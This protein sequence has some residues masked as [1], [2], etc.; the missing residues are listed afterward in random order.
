MSS[1]STNR[2]T[3]QFTIFSQTVSRWYR[4][5]YVR[6]IVLTLIFTLILGGVLSQTGWFASTQVKAGVICPSGYAFNSIVSQCAKV[7]TNR[8]IC[9]VGDTYNNNGTCTVQGG[10]QQYPASCPVN[11]PWVPLPASTTQCYVGVGDLGYVI[12][13]AGVVDGD[14]QPSQIYPGQTITCSFPLKGSTSN[15]Y[16][17]PATSIIVSV[18]TATGS[19]TDC[20]IVQNGT[21][22]AR[23]QCT[24]IPTTA[25]TLGLRNVLL[26]TGSGL[27]SKGTVTI[28]NA[29]LTTATE[30]EVSNFDPTNCSTYQSSEVVGN[31]SVCFSKLYERDGKLYSAINLATD[32]DLNVRLF[33]NNTSDTLLN[34]SSFADSIPVGFTRSGNASNTLV[35]QNTS[36]TLPISGAFSVSPQAGFYGQSISETIGNVEYGKKKFL[37]FQQCAYLQNSINNVGGSVTGSHNDVFSFANLGSSQFN[38][39][40]NVANIANTA[41]NCATGDSTTQLNP[42]LSNVSAIPMMA[43]KYLHLQQCVYKQ[44]TGLPNAYQNDYSLLINPTIATNYATGTGADNL[45]VKPLNCGAGEAGGANRVLDSSVSGEQTFDTVGNRYLHF[46]QCAY[47]QNIGIANVEQADI[48]TLINTSSADFGGASS[49]NNSSIQSLSCKPGVGGMLLNTNRSGVQTFDLFDATRGHGFISYTLQ[50]DSNLAIGSKHGTTGTFDSSQMNALAH[51]LSNSITIIDDQGADTQTWW[52]VSDDGINWS[53]ALSNMDVRQAVF[54]RMWYRNKVSFPIRQAQLKLVLPSDVTPDF[55][56]TIKACLHNPQT[57]TDTCSNDV[58]QAGVTLNPSIFTGNVLGVSPVAGINGEPITA[59]VGTIAAN[60]EGYVQFAFKKINTTSSPT[61]LVSF[62]AS[63]RGN[64]VSTSQ[65]NS[66]IQIA[67]GT[68]PSLTCPYLKPLGGIRDV[69][70]SD[71]ELRT[72]QDFYC[73]Y[74]AKIC[75]IVFMDNNAN[76]KFDV[77]EVGNTGST[78]QLRDAGGALLNTIQ[79]S[80]DGSV[81][82]VGLLANENYRIQNN[83]PLDTIVTTGSNNRQ[84]FIPYGT[85]TTTVLFGYTSAGELTISSSPTVNLGTFAVTNKDKP[86]SA[87]AVV[88]VSDTRSSLAGWLASCTVDDFV[89]QNLVAPA[90]PIANRF[91]SS[92][93]LLTQQ[94]TA[95]QPPNVTIGTT[96][97]VTNITDPFMIAFADPG[98]GVGVFDTTT[99]L[100]YIIPSFSQIGAYQT[101]VTCTAL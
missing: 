8:T 79:T 74:T 99:T 72:D 68:S 52:Q 34:S 67:Y 44:N 96:K 20:G 10:S 27:Q 29:T 87:P 84:S 54:T 92:P 3:K 55:S 82:F 14:C 19:S 51:N 42:I 80:A 75:P 9:E 58:G 47:N 69:T 13:N 30:T 73:N 38:S 49:I 81:C 66:N 62:L 46:N 95:N 5:R 50:P 101:T 25:A 77:T 24:N 100:G 11:E 94:G 41:V 31:G 90:L 53:T 98:Y 89:D 2:Y 93:T 35:D 76:G 88:T 85:S 83:D 59:K 91:S 57:N 28:T 26:N 78:V 18:A 4:H 12:D 70:V 86:V 37:N 23:L 56:N 45:N 36:I 22:S 64:G 60:T 97:T 61:I 7:A 40:S 39:S 43:H 65:P 15:N 48:M 71:A 17:F 32:Q 21:T 33:Y 63:L 6:A 1:I 16:Y